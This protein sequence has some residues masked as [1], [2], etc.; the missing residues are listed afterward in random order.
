MKKTQSSPLYQRIISYLESEIKHGSLKPGALLPC[1]Q[2]LVDKFGVSRGTARKAYDALVFSGLVERRSG[3]GSFVKGADPAGGKSALKAGVVVPSADVFD[4]SKDPVN[5]EIRLDTLNGVLAEAC[6]RNIE[7]ELISYSPDLAENPRKDGFVIL[8]S[9]RELVKALNGKNIPYSFFNLTGMVANVKTGVAV[10]LEEYLYEAL[11]YLFDM[12]HRRVAL[13]HGGS[14][15]FYRSALNERR[16]PFDETL[17]CPALKGTVED[18]RAAAEEL[19]SRTDKVDAIFCRSDIR[20]AGVL[21]C[22]RGRGI[23]VP[24][25]ISVMGF[26]NLK[27]AEE[28]GLTTF[29]T[30]RYDSGREAVRLLAA[31]MKSGSQEPGGIVSLKGKII[32]RNTVSRRNQEAL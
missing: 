4:P 16:I 6:A 31:V 13:I 7:L 15:D 28:L 19:L 3:Q 5:Y 12:G 18:A 26:D 10:E 8:D 17:L 22:L 1:E 32:E 27:L 20:A 11:S 2:E 21:D 9:Y 23:K 24:E 14:I 29:D 25:D 30:R